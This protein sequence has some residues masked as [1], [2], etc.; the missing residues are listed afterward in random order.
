M[1]ELYEQ[2]VIIHYLEALLKS[3]TL[4]APS[5]K[6][7]CDYLETALPFLGM[8]TNNDHLLDKMG[9]LQGAVLRNEGGRKLFQPTIK[10]IGKAVAARKKAIR[11]AEPGPLAKNISVIARELELDPLETEI[12]GLIIRYRIHDQLSSLFNDL[13]R[14]HMSV[15]EL[16][17]I[18]L[19]VE[20]K[21]LG[22]RLSPSGR[23]LSSGVIF[24]PPHLGKDIDDCF[25]VPDVIF[26]AMQKTLASLTDVRTHIL[27]EPARA[28]LAWEDFDHLEPAR[29]K[30]ATFLKRVVEN[31]MSGV[32]ILLWG[33]PGTG[34]TEFCKTLAHQLQLNLYALCETDEMGEEPSRK[35]RTSALK[36]AQSLLRYQKDSLLLFDEMDDLFENKGLAMFFGGKLS[37]GSKVFTNRLFESNPVPTLWTINDAALLD[38]S[39]I[40]RMALAIE[41]KVPPA[42][43]RA[44]VW[45]R[46]LD[47]HQVSLPEDEIN[48]LS[49]IEIA[50]AV[51]D[52]A[53]RFAGLVG[54]N[55]EDFQFATQGIIKAT[56][57]R[58]PMRQNKKQQLY[59]P[60]LINADTDLGRLA[61]NLASSNDRNFSLCLYG[62]PGTGKTAY[63]RYLA[64]RLG[65]PVLL[66]RASDLISKYLGES[67][68]NIALAFEEAVEKESF[69]V[70]DEADSL[71]GDR[72]YAQRSWEISQVNE[73]LTWME[74]HALPF[75]CTTNLMDRLDQASLRRF[76]FKCH[77][78]F[79]REDQ[80]ILAFSHF[81]GIDE[82]LPAITD[83]H[84]LTPGDFATVRQKRKFL[85]P[86]QNIHEIIK[87]LRIEGDLKDLPTRKTL[88][89][90]IG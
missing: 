1:A 68:Q 15:Y 23:L 55:L 86:D 76:T 62:P 77:F 29:E 3:N 33:S 56:T 37:M 70:F 88:G 78:D 7:V 66:K 39:V 53:V 87:L 83:V 4:T 30:L 5:L 81:F 63:V 50:P 84:H 80:V 46:L 19:G 35:E 31:N 44:N 90:S 42:R 60:E 20:R 45:R 71:L 49:M 24:Q 61:D 47:K 67:E 72:R 43:S 11:N 40:R 73:M 34:K 64:E 82:P 52:N 89:F 16:L 13:T 17:G 28:S 2:L 79:L 6:E 26:A 85:A 32:N 65:M 69:L 58:N 54:H 25:N 27:G 41:I 74:N 36:L 8:D 75:A 10:E 38:E 57:G 48:Q 22:E 12:F 59:L 21:E 18:C 51:A 9:E 14:A